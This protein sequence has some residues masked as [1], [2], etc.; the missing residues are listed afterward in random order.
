MSTTRNVVLLRSSHVVLFL[1]GVAMLGLFT[2]TPAMSGNTGNDDA[3][4]NALKGDWG[5]IKMNVRYRW[6]HV[7]QNGKL[8]TDGD[9]IRLRLGYLTPNIHQGVVVLLVH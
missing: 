1:C 7:E 9:P 2:A 5:Q 4:A 8:D 3:I 6:E